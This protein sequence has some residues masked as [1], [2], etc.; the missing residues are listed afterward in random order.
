MSG[1]DAAGYGPVELVLAAFDGAEPELRV[2]D[3]LAALAES[4]TIRLIDVVY[5]ARDDDGNATFAEIDEGGIDMGA[6]DLAASGVVAHD[7]LVDMASRLDP[8]TSALLLV[9]ELLWAKTLAA[10]LTEANGYVVDSVRIPAAVV[11]A[12]VAEADAF[13]LEQE[14]G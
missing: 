11:N 10:R 9:V 1:D 14:V 6:L 5:V 2:L 13:A 3:E 12:A 4:G 7:D 8:G